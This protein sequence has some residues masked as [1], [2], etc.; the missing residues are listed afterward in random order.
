[1][2]GPPYFARNT[3]HYGAGTYLTVAE[4]PVA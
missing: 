2:P 1:M 4:M 3:L